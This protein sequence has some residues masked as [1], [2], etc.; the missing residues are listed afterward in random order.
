[1]QSNLTTHYTVVDPKYVSKVVDE[2]DVDVVVDDDD[3]RTTF[4]IICV[5]Q[6]YDEIF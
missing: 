5:I 1:M 6:L 4:H 3:K 2:D